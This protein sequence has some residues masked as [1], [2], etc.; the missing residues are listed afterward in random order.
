MQQSDARRAVGAISFM[1]HA[2]EVRMSIRLRMRRATAS[3]ILSGAS[4]GACHDPSAPTPLPPGAEA[5]VPETVYREWWQQM[6]ICSGTKAPFDSVR[7]YVVRGEEPFRVRGIDYPVVGYWDPQNN[8]IVL[9]EYLVSQRAPV[10]RHESLHAII[11]RTDHP[12]LYF[13]ERC[14]ATIGGPDSPD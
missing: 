10:I 3:I 6:E 1:R 8:H 2:T 13:E 5:F 9:L 7:W 4:L 14:G 12:P 11:R